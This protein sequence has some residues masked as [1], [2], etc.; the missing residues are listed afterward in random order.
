MGEV[1]CHVHL[2]PQGQLILTSVNGLLVLYFP[3]IFL[4]PLMPC[5]KISFFRPISLL[6]SR[7][8]CFMFSFAIRLSA[9]P[10]SAL[11]RAFHLSCCLTSFWKVG[12]RC[13][14][15][16]PCMAFFVAPLILSWGCRGVDSE[17]AVVS[18]EILFR[19]VFCVLFLCSFRSPA[20]RLAFHA[21]SCSHRTSFAKKICSSWMR[22][23][24]AWP[25][26]FTS[27]SPLICDLIRTFQSSTSHLKKT[28]SIRWE[29][30]GWVVRAVLVCLGKSRWGSWVH[31]WHWSNFLWDL[32]IGL[33]A[34]G[35]RW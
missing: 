27:S 6:S 3:V 25:V 22:S 5:L 4:I 15:P 34:W 32:G 18:R 13:K 23:A 19:R 24:S 16:S 12:R 17:S 28:V 33:A 10:I 30:S 20:L 26:G 11:R 35:G 7:L 8:F 2:S 14:N 29:K 31:T 21:L 9:L 1:P